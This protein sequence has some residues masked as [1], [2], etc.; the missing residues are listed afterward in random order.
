MFGNFFLVHVGCPLW[1]EDWSVICSAITHWLE[2]RRTHNHILLSS[3]TP[4]PGGPG[5][6]IYIHQEQVGP[7]IPPGTGIHSRRLLRLPVRSFIASAAILQ[8]SLPKILFCAYSL[9]ATRIYQPLPN[10]S[11]LFCHTIP[12]FQLPCHSMFFSALSKMFPESALILICGWT[13]IYNG[14]PYTRAYFRKMCLI[15]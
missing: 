5:P 10:N 2:S 9:P 15:I 11:R 14:F 3:E 4:Q 13:W 1:R 12:V 8:T 6:H 7:V